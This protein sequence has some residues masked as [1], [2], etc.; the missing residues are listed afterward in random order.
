MGITGFTMTDY[1]AR[2]ADRLALGYF[3]GAVPLGYFQNAFLVYSNVLTI[4]TEPLHNIAVA[5]L[6]KLRNDA[7]EMKR[8]WALALSSMSFFS[9]A[10]FAVLAVTAQDFVL[11]LLGQ[12]WALAGPLLSIFAVRGIAH[13]VERTLGWIHVAAGR[14]DRWMRWGL[15]S[16]VCQIVAL[17]AGL[18]F[19]LIGVATAYTIAMFGLFVPAIAYAGR[20]V[21]IGIKDVLSVVGPQTIAGL[22]AIAFGLA[23]QQ[24]FLVDFSPLARFF[25]S[26][27]ICLAI[28]LAIALGVF[29][30]TGP[31]QL[32][33]S[34]LRD[35]GSMRSRESS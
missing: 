25:V 11:L 28:Y 20:P 27:Q 24:L 6:S 23:V 7:D 1:F 34:M 5:S 31:M 4:L 2:S 21:G 12:K 29:R 8:S 16:A 18:P 10:I 26:G 19:G 13:S 17:I 30:V 15:F 22:A 33:F 9:A 3:Y 32:V 35:F 14:S